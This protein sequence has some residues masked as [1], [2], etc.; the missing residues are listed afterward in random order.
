MADDIHDNSFEHVSTIMQPSTP[1]KWTPEDA[2]NFIS[3]AINEAQKPTMA[4]LKSR[5]VSKVIYFFTCIVLLALGGGIFY[6]F[7]WMKDIEWKD[8]EAKLISEREVAQKKYNEL[9]ETKLNDAIKVTSN[10]MD[11]SELSRELDSSRKLIGAS[12]V[13]LERLNQRNTDL[14]KENKSLTD[15]RD[16]ARAEVIEL[17]ATLKKSEND[18]AH[19]NKIKTEHTKEAAKLTRHIELLKLANEQQKGEITI[20]RQ[21]LATAQKMVS[22]LGQEDEIKIEVDSQSGSKGADSDK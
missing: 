16:L 15:E 17:K 11:N 4:A 21:R 18:I 5:G 1:V 22:N 3:S 10:V 2:A 14:L 19:I 9:L 12:K 13:E 6:Y 20:L 8:R 7:G